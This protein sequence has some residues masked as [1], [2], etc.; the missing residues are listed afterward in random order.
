MKIFIVIYS[1][2]FQLEL[3]RCMPKEWAAKVGF[4]CCRPRQILTAHVLSKS[5]SESFGETWLFAFFTAWESTA[6]LPMW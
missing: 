2:E 4:A 6:N 3:K 1:I 5:C